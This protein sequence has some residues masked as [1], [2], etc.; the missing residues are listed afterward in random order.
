MARHAPGVLLG[1]DELEVSGGPILLVDDHQLLVESL[2][3]ALRAEGLEPV[4][5]RLDTDVVAQA[6]ERTAAVVLLDLDLGPGQPPGE[7]LVPGL[8]DAGAVVVVVSATDDPLRTG[9][10]IELGAAGV[11]PKSTP[12]HRLLELVLAAA[13][14]RPVQ[15]HA[16][17]QDLLAAMREA[18]REQHSRLE[19]F[20][21]LT[22]R[23]ADVLTLL[24][25]GWAAERVAR[26]FV[27]S[28]ATV[29]SQIRGVLTKLE[30]GTQLAAV[31]EAYRVGWAT[32][33]A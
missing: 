15:S 19:P 26:H 31:A 14:G 28:E 6:S 16:A 25:R 33:A 24:M 7:T 11:V 21:R 3:A 5:A 2:A 9:T 23:E 27:V 8:V 4:L 18:R 13:D 30:V 29:R 32:P 1:R 12:F 10:C 20:G 17:R 22:P